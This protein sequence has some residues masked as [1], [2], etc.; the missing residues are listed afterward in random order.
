MTPPRQLKD[1]WGFR[2]TARYDMYAR[3]LA[4]Y[5]AHGYK[6]QV[7]RDPSLPA[8]AVVNSR[9]WDLAVAPPPRRAVV[10]E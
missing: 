5:T 4:D 7:V 2:M 1:K 6:P 9:W 3:L 10:E 8:A